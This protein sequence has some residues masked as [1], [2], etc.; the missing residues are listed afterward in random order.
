MSL[1]YVAEHLV[2]KAT[3]MGLLDSPVW[4]PL[5]PYRSTIV[6]FDDQTKSFLEFTNA[7]AF[8]DDGCRAAYPGNDLWKCLRGASRLPFVRTPYF[9]T[10]SQYD[11]FGISV[12]FFGRYAPYIKV[13]TA[14]KEY[15]EKY[16]NQLVQYL[17]VP[18]V[19]SG[20]TIYSTACYTHCTLT[21]NSFFEVNADGVPLDILFHRWLNTKYPRRATGYLVD[22][23]KGFNCCPKAQQKSLLGQATTTTVPTTPPSGSES[24]GDTW[25]HVPGW[26]WNR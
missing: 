25:L 11:L 4:L 17:P 16:R 7:S 3:P 19:G 5:Q 1:D 14:Q 9:L 26:S 13:S 24:G 15:A 12:N 20:Q 6:P 21:S 22:R 10:Q 2:G 18:A 23:C 8:I